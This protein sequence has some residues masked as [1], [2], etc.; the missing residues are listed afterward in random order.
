[1]KAASQQPPQLRTFASDRFNVRYE[2]KSGHCDTRRLPAYKG[3]MNEALQPTVT[4]RLKDAI[5]VLYHEFAAPVPTVIEGCPCCIET[6][7]V[8]VLLTTPLRQLTG[9][10]LW[11]YI[12]GVFLTVGGERDFRYLIPRIFE[13]SACDVLGEVP[14]PEIVLG[15]LKLANWQSWSISE[16]QAIEEFIDAWFEHKLAGDLRKEDEDWVNC[17]VDRILCGASRSEIPIT[18]WLKR[19]QSPFA[20]P[21]LNELKILH[22]DGPPPFWEDAPEGL[23]ELAVILK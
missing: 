22:A 17:E 12:T 15:K 21:V 8:D 9:K 16:R 2:R 14:D 13:I 19:L 23:N 20:A 10:Q 11:R 7:G 3:L 18:R 1:M 5:E 4:M 6:R